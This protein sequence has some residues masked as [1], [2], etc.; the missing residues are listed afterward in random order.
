MAV[1]RLIRRH[2][3]PSFVLMAGVA[4]PL[5]T[6]LVQQLSE[7]GGRT[8]PC[9]DYAVLELGTRSFLLGE[10][11]VGLYSREGWRH[12][13]PAPFMWSAPFSLLP[14]RGFARFQIGVLALH[15]VALM[16]VLIAFARRSSTTTWMAVVAF[17]SFFIWRFDINQLREP[18]NPYMAMS[19]LVVAVVAASLLITGESS[20]W[21]PVF[22][23]S[24]SM[25]AQTHMGA[26]P[27]IGVVTVALIVVTRRRRLVLERRPI[28]I[29]VAAALILWVLPIAD[30]VFGDHNAFRVFGSSGDGPSMGGGSL[31]RGIV[32][33]L[34]LSPSHLGRFFGTSSAF[35]DGGTP[36]ILSWIIAMIAVVGG[37][38]VIRQRR[39]NP[40]AAWLA[41]FSLAGIT[42]TMAALL[43]ADGPFFR[44][45][46]LPITGLS[47]V[48]WLSVVLMVA[49][50]FAELTP[51]VAIV[52]ALVAGTASTI[53]VNQGN[54]A[55]SYSNEYLDS[56]VTQIREKCGTLPSHAVVEVEDSVEWFDA[57]PFIDQIDRCTDV[58]V[59]GTVGFV[60]G[61][62]F[63][64][65]ESDVVNVRIGR[66]SDI[67][68]AGTDIATFDGVVVRVL[69]GS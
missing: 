31:V 38:M 47:L 50:R 68:D 46:L 48:L 5:A 69:D 1:I 28:L 22:V 53:D 49:E 39:S 24:A 67:T 7:L 36:S 27:T 13:G 20:W 61:Q 11:L 29:S 35:V 30:A 41:A 21:L 32:W 26:V 14:F 16:T 10:Q 59:L 33:M 56:M 65:D 2:P 23:V 63:V 15:A 64:A 40:F 12:P 4:L 52:L 43:L 3:W 25:A 8:I 62:S 6:L 60:S 19:L 9:C 58:Q 55:Q 45:L 42:L 57:A 51:V 17:I 34:S 66:G 44:Y 37:V 18:W 54:L